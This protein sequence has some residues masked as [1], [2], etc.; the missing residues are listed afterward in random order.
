MLAHSA[1]PLNTDLEQL[2]ESWRE[3]DI[4]TSPNTIFFYK[5]DT[6][7]PQGRKELLE[8]PEPPGGASLSQI[9]SHLICLLYGKSILQ[10]K[11]KFNTTRVA[12][13]PYSLA[14]PS[15]TYYKA[16]N[17]EAAQQTGDGHGKRKARGMQGK[18]L[19][20]EAEER[21][22]VWDKYKQNAMGVQ[23]AV[24]HGLIQC[25]SSEVTHAKLFFPMLSFFIQALNRYSV[26]V[27]LVQRTDRWARKTEVLT[28]SRES[29]KKAN[30]SFQLVTNS[31]MEKPNVKQDSQVWKASLRK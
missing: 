8:V 29:N 9:P 4:P 17:I 16:W 30:S 22:Q 12:K 19:D 3:T 21:L 20:N 23:K 15:H 25:P 7:S 18:N 11:S 10:G 2:Y 28:T 26:R 27:Y 31:L 24:A 14:Y 13:L 6:H 1:E 5:P